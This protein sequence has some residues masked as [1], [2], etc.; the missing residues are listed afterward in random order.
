MKMII[1]S[2]ACLILCIGFLVG[3]KQDSSP[4]DVEK[5]TNLITHSWKGYNYE[6]VTYQQSSRIV[7]DSVLSF[8]FKSDG[9]CTLSQITFSVMYLVGQ[10]NFENGAN[11]I[12][13]TLNKQPSPT[14]E[15]L[16]IIELTANQ[17]I[18]GDTTSHGYYLVP[19]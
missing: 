4:T 17:L 3:C 19:Q 1:F 9:S 12:R 2:Y 15:V 7:K 10:W 6:V 18:I 13:L 14:S 16:P 11:N 5:K 8:E